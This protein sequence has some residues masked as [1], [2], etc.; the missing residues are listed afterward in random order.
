[1]VCSRWLTRVA[2]L[3]SAV[4]VCVPTEGLRGDEVSPHE[5]GLI[6]G[7]PPGSDTLPEAALTDELGERLD[8]LVSTFLEPAG[9]DLR[10][11]V[12]GLTGQ[13]ETGPRLLALWENLERAVS[14]TRALDERR[15]LLKA[16]RERLAA[17]LTARLGI[18]AK[19]AEKIV[20]DTVT[21]HLAKRTRDLHSSLMC[22]CDSEDWTRTLAGCPETCAQPQKDLI[23]Q[24]LRE[25]LTDTEVI[26]RMVRQAVALKG[27]EG[28][29]VKA[30]SKS[31]GLYTPFV[32]LLVAGV[33]VALFLR[34]LVKRGA[35]EG[36]PEPSQETGDAEW[37]ERLERE[38]K[39]MDG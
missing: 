21:L 26:D 20:G 5:R 8:Q 27:P 32:I 6:E 18:E 29:K 31:I 2:S 30:S 16:L 38:L 34:R 13:E 35:Q 3:F 19:R 14:Q 33:F 10:G 36:G 1:M 28:V 23:Q 12:A 39:E 24:W 7:M 37:G 11:E 9:E 17:L 4:L 15:T 25:G 22:W